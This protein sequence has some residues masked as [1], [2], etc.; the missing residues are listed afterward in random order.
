MFANVVANADG[1]IANFGVVAFANGAFPPAD[2]FGLPHFL[3]DNL[4]KFQRGAGRG[5]HFESMVFLDNFDVGVHV[6]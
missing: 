3:G 5:V 6:F 4:T 2:G 1:V